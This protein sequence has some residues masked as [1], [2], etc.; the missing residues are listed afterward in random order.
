MHVFPSHS[1]L[2]IVTPESTKNLDTKSSKTLGSGWTS[3]KVAYR[4]RDFNSGY[5]RH[6]ILRPAASLAALEFTAEVGVVDLVLMDSVW[7][8]PKYRD[9]DAIEVYVT[10]TSLWRS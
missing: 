9:K 4:H 7:P 10:V 3:R 1:K 8:K 6:L 2:G 5:E